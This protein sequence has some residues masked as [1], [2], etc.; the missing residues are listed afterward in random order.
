MP[1]KNQEPFLEE[2]LNSIRKQ[3]KQDWELIVVDDHSDDQSS[4]ILSIWAKKEP[5]IQTF[6]NPGSGIVDA[7][8]FG[9]SK[10]NSDSSGTN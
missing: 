2:C 10:S 7:L 4:S 8:N 1:I 6:E 3:T 9:I 5:R